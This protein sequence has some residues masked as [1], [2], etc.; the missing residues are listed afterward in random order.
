MIAKY[1]NCNV[2]KDYLERVSNT[3]TDGTTMYGLLEA[4][5]SLGFDAY[6]KKGDVSDIPKISLPVIAHIKIDEKK[7]LYHYVV[8]TNITDKKVII[9]DPGKLIKTLSIDEFS[10]IATGNYLFIKK[11]ASI[12]RFVKVKIIRNAML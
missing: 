5:L 6:G 10:K 9:K 12:K 3:F 7:N 11:T 8:I 2:S 4:A 1:Y